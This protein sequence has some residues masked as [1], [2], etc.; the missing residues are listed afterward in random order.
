MLRESFIVG[1]LVLSFTMLGCPSQDPVRPKEEAGKSPNTTQLPSPL[2]SIS[3]PTPRDAGYEGPVGIPADSRG[4][5]VIRD[6]RPQEPTPLV[7]SR[8]LDADRLANREMQGLTMT[9]EWTWEGVAAAPGGAEVN[10]PGIKAARAATR[11]LW[12]IELLEAGRLRIVFDSVSYPLTKYTELRARHDAYG[13]IL[14]W[15]EADNYRVI[16]SGALRALL[17][18]RRVDTSPLV[19]GRTDKEQPGRPYFGFPTRSVGVSTPWGKLDLVQART[20]NA[21]SGGVLFCRLLLEL[22]GARPDSPV[23]EE[24]R[25]PV[26]ASYAWKDG[27]KVVLEVSTL[28]IRP[29]FQ[30]TMFMIPPSRATFT[31]VGLP[32]DATGLFLTREQMEAFRSRPIEPAT[33][34]DRE[35]KGAPG[36]GFFAVNRTDALRFLCIDGVPVTW[37]PAHGEQYVIGSRPGKYTAQWRSFLGTSIEPPTEVLIPARIVLGEEPEEAGAP[38]VDAAL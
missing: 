31:D 18:E 1:T 11:H 32:P 16:P 12:Q 24:G 9:A 15:P 3:T 35:S 5:L 20:S 29:D 13:H 37:V 8:P 6:A 27:G 7:P 4:R 38:E 33:R 19:A 14:V 25:V 26:R 34:S 17:D 36:E 30:P 22:I 2:S 10:Q 23:C 21:G 28:M